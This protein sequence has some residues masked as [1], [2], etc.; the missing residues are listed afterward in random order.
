[1]LSLGDLGVV[2]SGLGCLVLVVRVDRVG[3]YGHRIRR[4]LTSSGFGDE[5]RVVHVVCNLEGWSQGDAAGVSR[6]SEPGG[7]GAVLGVVIL[8]HRWPGQPRLSGDSPC[9]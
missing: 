9:A 7:R 6:I 2:Q 1:M 3:L 8:G 5:L 4:A